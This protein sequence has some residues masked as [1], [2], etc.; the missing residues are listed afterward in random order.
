MIGY[1]IILHIRSAAVSQPSDTNDMQ[2]DS[3][4][5]D[6]SLVV[7]RDPTSHTSTYDAV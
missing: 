4:E 6:Y 5:Q 1:H 7:F 3:G 2:H